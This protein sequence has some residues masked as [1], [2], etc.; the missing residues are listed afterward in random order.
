[1]DAIDHNSQRAAL[2]RLFRSGKYQRAS[3][4]KEDDKDITKTN[5]VNDIIRKYRNKAWKQ[6]TKDPQ[7]NNFYDSE[8]TSWKE[9]KEIK[10]SV[11]TSAPPTYNQ[12]LSF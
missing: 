9:Q 3:I 10:T 1:M 2:Q 8:G 6:V 5:L 4:I 12:L 11:P 7:Y